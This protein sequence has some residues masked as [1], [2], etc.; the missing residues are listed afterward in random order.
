MNIRF[1]AS[2]DPELPPRVLTE[3]EREELAA[4]LKVREAAAAQLTTIEQRIQLF[5]LTARDRRGLR[6]AITV[7]I[8][9]GTLEEE[10]PKP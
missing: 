10:W 3:G 8:T 2:L 9:T 1:G 5:L 4:M 7:D 6:G